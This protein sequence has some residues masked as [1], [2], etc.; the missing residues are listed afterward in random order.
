[1]QTMYSE[2]KQACQR[3]IRTLRHALRA[4][5]SQTGLA[6]MR[7]QLLSLISLV[8]H[9]LCYLLWHRIWPQEYD[10]AP[11]RLVAMV[12]SGICL[13]AP[14]FSRR[15][16]GVLLLLLLSYQL[17]FFFTFMFLMNH[18]APVTAETLLVTL[19]ALFHF[20][21]PIA[22]L[23]YA[24]GTAA[25]CASVA[26][27]AGPDVMVAASVLQQLPIHAFAVFVISAV[28]IGRNV[29]EREKLA[30]L[31]AGLASVSHELRTPLISVEANMRG[32]LRAL[33]ESAGASSEERL[34][35]GEALARIQFEVRH[36]NHMIDLF[37][38]SA[39]AVNR[40][41]R[42]REPVSMAG[43]LESMLQRY[44]FATS[45]QRCAV[46]VDV[47]RDFVFAGQADLSVVILLNL[48]RNAL[49]AIHRAGKGRVRVIVDGARATPR[50]LF[51]D[52]ACGIS[53]RH[54][55]LIFR[56]FYSYPPHQGSGIGLAL[57]RDIMSA[58]NARIRCVTRE[59]AYAIFVL[60][61]PRDPVTI[62]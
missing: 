11:L 18:A 36:M 17:S 14:H 4:A 50:L 49:K 59:Q 43:A 53:A 40:N 30:G 35:C 48:L 42:P 24:I 54:L 41:L 6:P 33:T 56:R 5:H 44:P 51:I 62:R 21:T 38:L 29:L 60:E 55:P 25:A 27:I 28:K 47:R 16:Q 39:T 32:L 10:S 58:W 26:L 13:F 22:L 3:R 57:C 12:Q 1:M 20:E 15:W 61:F 8:G 31:Q 19:I 46:T 45:A 2:T 23:A 9:P 52:T 7:L 34:H 37:L